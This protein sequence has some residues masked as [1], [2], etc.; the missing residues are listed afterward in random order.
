MLY[1]HNFCQLANYEIEINFPEGEINNYE[2]IYP[3]EEDAPSRREWL[4]AMLVEK[5]QD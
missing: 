4:A 1:V 3:V 2:N 5:L